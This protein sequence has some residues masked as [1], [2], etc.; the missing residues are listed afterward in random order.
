MPHVITETAEEVLDKVYPVLDRGFV[1][2]VDYMGGDSRVVQAARI[3]TGQGTKT[4]PEDARLIN[5]LM[6]HRHTSP[7]EMVEFL[8]HIKLPIF[9]MRQ[10]VRHR[11]ASL[12]EYS[13]RYSVLEDEFYFP[14]LEEIGYQSKENKQA[15]TGHHYAADWVKSCVEEMSDISFDKYKR[16]IDIDVAR[17]MARIVVPVNV[18]TQCYWKIDFHNL[19][20]FLKLRLEKG[21]QPQIQ[22]YAK[23]MAEI[24]S[25]V[26]PVAWASFEEH[27]LYSKTFSRTEAQQ[28]LQ[29]L[30][31][32][33]E[34][35][36]AKKLKAKLV[37]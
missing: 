12:N 24:A 8:F 29:L 32:L 34:T 20:H 26:M 1:R 22:E 36:E 37:T 18:Y 16:M 19:C 28:L 27:V 35:E 25:K 31:Q 21:A 14:E 3:S 10:L 6:K 5:Y 17:E 7:L 23:V 9:V 30:S 33:P 15:S 2:L 11:T 4:P 13:A